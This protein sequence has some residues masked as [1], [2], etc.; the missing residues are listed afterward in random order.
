MRDSPG[1]LACTAL[2]KI[3]PAQRATVNAE[4]ELSEVTFGTIP[5]G[6]PGKPAETSGLKPRTLARSARFALAWTAEAAVSTWICTLV[7]SL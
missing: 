4:K 5:G 3:L 6:L 1:A 2:A 7:Q